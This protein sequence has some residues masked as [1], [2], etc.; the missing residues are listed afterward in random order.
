MTKYHGGKQ[1]IGDEIAKVIKHVSEHVED[2]AG[3]KFKGYL[4]PFSGMM[5]V[6]QHIPELFQDH[7]SFKYRAGDINESVIKMWKAT[8]RGWNPPTSCSEK[9]FYILKG[10]GKSSAEKGF[11]GHTCAFRG[12]YFGTYYNQVTTQ[13]IKGNKKRVLDISNILSKNKVE[14]KFVSY[15]YWKK[16][17]G[18]I[19]YCDP[20]YF[21]NSLYPDEF[22]KYR[23]F[24]SNEFYK[25]AEKM[26]ETNLVFVSERAK[27][28]YKVVGKFMNDEKLYLI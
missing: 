24:D 4:E 18:Y 19:I 21:S 22:N 27:L 8:Q 5:G 1:R 23:N 25:W 20:P 26:S 15:S 12:V 11:I 10:N 13:Q 28:P 2:H 7:K 14:L 3:I 17:K 9:K 6:Y 16:T